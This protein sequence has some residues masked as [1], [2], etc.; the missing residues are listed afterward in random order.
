MVGILRKIGRGHH[1]TLEFGRDMVNVFLSWELVGNWG[2][3]GRGPNFLVHVGDHLAS[4]KMGLN[5][6]AVFLGW[7]PTI[8]GSGLLALFL[9]VSRYLQSGQSTPTMGYVGELG[10]S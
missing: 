9:D 4:F 8:L 2:R 7:Q 3:L 1:M 6:Q 5:G 10:V